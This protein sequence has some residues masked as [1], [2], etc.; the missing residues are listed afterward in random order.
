MRINKLLIVLITLLISVVSVAQEQKMSRTEIDFFKKQVQQEASN[1]QTI[2]MDFVQHKKLSFLTKQIESSG[3][4]YYKAKDMLH[5]KYTTPYQYSIIFK[6][7]MVHINNQGKK[8]DISTSSNLVLGKVNKL[9]VGSVSG[10]L[11][12]DQEFVIDYYKDKQYNIVYFVPK[13][14]Q[15]KE[16]IEKIELYFPTDKYHVVQVQ[17]KESSGDYTKIIFK[18]RKTNVVLSE[19]D[20]TN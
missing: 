12:D 20:F 16:V 18:N 1:T 15:L 2:K 6:K 11:F 5:W 14:K 17:L 8:N 9:I 4:M 3:I 13:D 19:S 7:G 10:N